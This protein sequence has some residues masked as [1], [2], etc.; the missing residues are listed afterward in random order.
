MKTET[1]QLVKKL[2]VVALIVLA[3]CAL[4][5]PRAMVMIRKTTIKL[6]PVPER[7]TRRKDAYMAGLHSFLKGLNT[8]QTITGRSLAANR[9]A[10]IMNMLLERNSR[11]SREAP[12]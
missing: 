2:T 6:C 12:C 11:G 3:A 10:P 8:A 5:T 9:P 4:N 1:K 7:S